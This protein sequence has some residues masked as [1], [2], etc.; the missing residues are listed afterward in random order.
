MVHAMLHIVAWLATL[1]TDLTALKTIDVQGFSK[2]VGP[3]KPAGHILVFFHAKDTWKQYPFHKEAARGATKMIRSKTAEV[4]FGHIQVFRFKLTGKK[5]ASDFIQSLLGVRADIEN[6]TQVVLYDR[7]APYR[8]P[9]HYRGIMTSESIAQ[10]AWLCSMPDIMHAHNLNTLSGLTKLVPLLVACLPS[11]RHD[12][13]LFLEFHYS[14]LKLRDRYATVLVTKDAACPLEALPAV[15]L[16]LPTGELRSLKDPELF[17]RSPSD[18]LLNLQV[19]RI[20]EMTADNN[21][22]FLDAGGWIVIAIFDHRDEHLHSRIRSILEPLVDVYEGRGYRVNFVTASA[23]LYGH[24]F[25]LA[26][27]DH[28][29]VFQYLDADDHKLNA[30]IEGFAH[31]PSKQ[32]KIRRHLQKIASTVRIDYS[33]K[34][35]VVKSV[36]NSTEARLLR[37]AFSVYNATKERLEERLDS[38]DANPAF[39]IYLTRSGDPEAQ[40]L[41]NLSHAILERRIRPELHRVVSKWA[42]LGLLEDWNSDKVP[43][44]CY[45]FVRRYAPM[46]RRA[47]NNHKDTDSM[48]TANVLLSDS[49]DFEG[50]LVVYPEAKDSVNLGPSAFPESGLGS[51]VFHRSDL[52]HGVKVTGGQRYSWIL[53]FNYTCESEDHATMHR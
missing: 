38:V 50:G 32:T 29:L 22:R 27:T 36:L 7:R 11:I 16:T 42:S 31:E 44:L 48:V 30:V 15:G 3:S 10:F 4:H 9:Q 14:A 2:L 13:Q 24:Q 37:Q 51:I 28:A 5:I 41:L 45:S 6:Y 43:K 19:P 35:A 39:E 25:G 47:L 34:V 21:H 8:K 46:E 53:W 12:S 40:Q 20:A 49:T 33:E 23:N 26:P 1:T 17:A 52:Y 18:W